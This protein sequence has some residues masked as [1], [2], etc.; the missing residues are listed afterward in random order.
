[1]FHSKKLLK[2]YNF[3]ILL[4]LRELFKKGFIQLQNIF[5]KTILVSIYNIC[6]RTGWK[7]KWQDNIMGVAGIIKK[8]T[9][10]QKNI[11]IFLQSINTFSITQEAMRNSILGG[12]GVSFSNV[13]NK[14]PE[15]YV[16]VFTTYTDPFLAL[17]NLKKIDGKF[18]FLIKKI[19]GNPI[20]LLHAYECIKSNPRNI[21][22]GVS[23]ET[24]KGI[25]K[26]WFIKT[27]LLL[28]SGEYSFK[29]QRLVQIPKSGSIKTRP[30]TITD[31]RDKIIQKAFQIVL[32][33]I[34]E[35]KLKSFHENSH[36]FR[37]GRNCHTALKSIK[38]T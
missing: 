34:Y 17:R 28:K 13:P 22:K 25:D 30:L 11:N 20:F 12:K 15:G 37:T 16:G 26:N 4:K 7:L 27:S 5:L 2:L 1:M 32:D 23:S 19:I 18:R 35:H 24:L 31:P 33:Y 6:L 29:L 8:V 10:S 36:G 14:C 3:L 21:I 9:T 38:Y